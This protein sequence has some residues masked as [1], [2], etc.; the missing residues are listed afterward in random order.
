MNT[1]ANNLYIGGSNTGHYFLEK[2]LGGNHDDE[3]FTIVI[4]TY[5]REKILSLL[6]DKYLKLAYL[7]KIIVVWNSVDSSPSNSFLFKYKRFIEINKLSVIKSDKNSLNNRFLPYRQIE[8]D[9]KLLISS[10]V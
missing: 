8:T 2:G 1:I 9:G 10:L 6:V 3:Q 5:K 7:N 4:L